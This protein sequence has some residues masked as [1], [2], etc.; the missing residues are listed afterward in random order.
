MAK[1]YFS[2]ADI[3]EYIKT[4]KKQRNKTGASLHDFVVLNINRNFY[5]LIAISVEFPK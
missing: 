3:V 5:P 1:T 2:L 4:K